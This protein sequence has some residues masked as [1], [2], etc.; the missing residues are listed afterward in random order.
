MKIENKH[1]WI[2]SLHKTAKAF[3]IVC[4]FGILFT[5]VNIGIVERKIGF[6]VCGIASRINIP[7]HR[8]A[9][10]SNVHITLHFP[11]KPFCPD[12]RD[13][14]RSG[15]KG[16]KGTASVTTNMLLW[17]CDF[18]DYVEV[19]SG[20]G[21][22]IYLITDCCQSDKNIIDIR[23]DTTDVGKVEMS[24]FSNVKIKKQSV[25]NRNEL[26]KLYNL[27]KF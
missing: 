22:G 18:L 23:F 8:R 6:T 5:I 9:M 14:G 2:T 19:L 3:Y 10:I 12:S 4:F 27:K 17:Y 1:F 21:K 26:I 20:K 16:F 15:V 7:I 11:C 25:K 13:I 24:Y